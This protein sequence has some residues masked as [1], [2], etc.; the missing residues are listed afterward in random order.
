MSQRGDR[1]IP[2][3][4]GQ[5]CAVRT[6]GRAVN[7]AAVRKNSESRMGSRIPEPNGEVIA[8]RGNPFAIRA[9]A[10]AADIRL[11]PAEH[12]HLR[13]GGHI[14]EPD[15]PIPLGGCQLASIPA[16]SY[17]KKRMYSQ[18]CTVSNR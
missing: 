14:P 6:N 16:K 17:G 7:D 13:S 11:M 8:G 18:G 10:D 12:G 1:F 4:S 15:R 2:A 3:G 9:V 5:P